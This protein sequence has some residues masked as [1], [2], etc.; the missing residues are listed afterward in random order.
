MFTH[1]TIGSNDLPKAKDF[2]TDVLAPLGLKMHFDAGAMIG[3]GGDAPQFMLVK[4]INGQPAT[5]ANGGTIGILAPSQAAVKEFHK[6]ALARGGKDEG[7]PGP[8]DA[9]PNMYS[10]YIR[11]LDGNKIVAITFAP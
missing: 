11:D 7:A 1:V 10:A 2:Y 8:R 9:A 5:A 3:F 4:P 6:R